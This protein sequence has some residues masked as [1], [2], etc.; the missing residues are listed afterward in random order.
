MGVINV[1]IEEALIVMRSTI[2]AGNDEDG[3]A[4]AKISL[5]SPGPG[6]RDPQVEL[7]SIKS[8]VSAMCHC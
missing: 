1:T 6:R 7:P 8:E 5:T 3:N 4:P 2:R